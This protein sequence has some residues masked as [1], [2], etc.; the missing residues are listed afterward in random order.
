MK[1]KELLHKVKVLETN[2]DPELE[3]TGVNYDSRKVEAGDLFIAIS[4]LHTDA[5]RHVPEAIA[6]GAVAILCEAPNGEAPAEAGAADCPTVR[7]DR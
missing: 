7:W 2:A 6:R 1:L 3:I 4:G 5:R